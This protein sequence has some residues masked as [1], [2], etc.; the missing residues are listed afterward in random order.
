VW[1]RLAGGASAEELARAVAAT[2]AVEPDAARRDVD[3][4]IADEQARL[5]SDS[6][7]GE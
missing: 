2:F 4:L 1:E 7:G 6:S 3:A 5:L